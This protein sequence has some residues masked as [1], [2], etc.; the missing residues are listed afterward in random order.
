MG[1]TARIHLQSL[2][3]AQGLLLLYLDMTM[4]FFTLPFQALVCSLLVYAVSE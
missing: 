2:G 4:P 3:A 1:H